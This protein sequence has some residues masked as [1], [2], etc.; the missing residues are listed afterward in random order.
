VKKEHWQAPGNR[1]M[2]YYPGKVPREDALDTRAVNALVNY[3]CYQ[4]WRGPLRPDFVRGIPI[5]PCIV[6]AQTRGQ[7]LRTSNFGRVTLA[8]VERWLALFGLGLRD[9][10]ASSAAHGC[11]GRHNQPSDRGGVTVTRETLESWSARCLLRLDGDG[12]YSNHYVCNQEP[13][14]TYV[15]SGPAGMRRKRKA[16]RTHGRKLYVDGIE[17]P[18][19]DAVLTMLN[20]TRR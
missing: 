20:A 8:K 17:C 16:E 13:R 5:C 12:F 14:L 10:P 6:A 4:R 15:D 2:F 18:D 11:S 19:I 9:F 1:M 3:F 7:L